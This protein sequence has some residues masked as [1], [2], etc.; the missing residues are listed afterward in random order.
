VGCNALFLPIGV[1]CRG[2]YRRDR[3]V[4]PMRKNYTIQDLLAAMML[5]YWIGVFMM[6]F[7][8]E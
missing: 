3:G 1:C 2:A 5:G 8:V 7:W 4:V 6:A